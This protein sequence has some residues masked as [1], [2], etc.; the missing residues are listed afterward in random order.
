MTNF[1][2]GAIEVVETIF[3][4]ENGALCADLVKDTMKYSGT[5]T[6]RIWNGLTP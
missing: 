1:E 3:E 6:M 4:R 5:R 2:G